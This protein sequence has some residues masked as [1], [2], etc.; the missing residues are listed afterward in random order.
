M[1][2]IL[3]TSKHYFILQSMTDGTLIQYYITLYD[4]LKV[5]HF[6]IKLINIIHLELWW[7]VRP[8]D[9]MGLNHYKCRRCNTYTL[10][11]DIS[12]P[13]A[14]GYTAFPALPSLARPSFGLSLIRA[15][16]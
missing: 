15:S 13:F 16:A 11:K 7:G 1:K 3:L 5:K 2:Y 14:L 8:S 10:L 9:L 12:S 4:L 6:K